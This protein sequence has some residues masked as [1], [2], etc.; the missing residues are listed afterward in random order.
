MD[1]TSRRP[2]SCAL[3]QGGAT[4]RAAA[5]TKC[6]VRPELFAASW[7]YAGC[8]ALWRGATLLDEPERRV[9]ARFDENGGE[10]LHDGAPVS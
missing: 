6:G 1:E 9:V 5:V 4:R 10:G 8:A 7:E 2:P 3:E